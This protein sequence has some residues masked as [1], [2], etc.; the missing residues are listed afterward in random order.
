MIGWR[1]VFIK[2]LCP[3]FFLLMRN[4][5]VI[6]LPTH[7]KKCFKKISILPSPKN[8]TVAKCFARRRHLKLDAH[9]CLISDPLP[10]L[11]APTVSQHK[12]TARTIPCFCSFGFKCSRS[13]SKMQLLFKLLYRLCFFH[14]TLIQDYVKKI[15]APILEGGFWW[16]LP[17]SFQSVRKSH[18]L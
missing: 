8:A 6:F 12:S 14:F 1:F 16:L 13:S 10:T 5:S 3:R 15:T 7:V 9:P 11:K 17:T 18:N 4:Y 2:F